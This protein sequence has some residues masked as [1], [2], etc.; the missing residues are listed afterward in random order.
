MI[1]NNQIDA[2]E[3]PN[4]YVNIDYVPLNENEP[5]NTSIFIERPISHQVL[6]EPDANVKDLGATTLEQ[7]KASICLKD[8]ANNV[9]EIRNSRGFF[10]ASNSKG[11][12]NNSV[13]DDSLTLYD[14]LKS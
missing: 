7:E 11:I 9:S 14:R 3:A 6:D 10:Q 4:R 5:S 12:K 1:P 8:L 2:F 13:C